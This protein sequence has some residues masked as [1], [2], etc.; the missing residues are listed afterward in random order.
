MK[1]D[2]VSVTTCGFIS[3]RTGDIFVFIPE[4]LLSEIL[5]LPVPCVLFNETR[6]EYLE[7][8][9]EA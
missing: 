1:V 9:L 8:L 3:T 6:S 4:Y 2:V 7:A 5:G